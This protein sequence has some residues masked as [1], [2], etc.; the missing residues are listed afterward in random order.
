MWESQQDELNLLASKIADA[1]KN[2]VQTRGKFAAIGPDLVRDTVSRMLLRYDKQWGGFGNAPKFTN[3]S[4]LMFLLQEAYRNINSETIA[5]AEHTL[6]MMAHGGVYDQIGGG[7]HRYST[8]PYWLVPHFEKMLYHQAYMARVY[9]MAYQYTG[10]KFYARIA[11][12]T[13]NY[14]LRDMTS[15]SGGFYSAS[16]AESDEEEG[17]YYV[18]TVNQIQ[19]YLP[20]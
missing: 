15:S 14:I 4:S 5:A 18:W 2:S 6:M 13:L 7:F 1:V 10:N 16:D 17:A 19:D 12:Q 8:D 11:E 9:L 20:G 3:E